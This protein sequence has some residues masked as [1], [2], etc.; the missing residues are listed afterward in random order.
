MPPVGFADKTGTRRVRFVTGVMH[1]GVDYGPDFDEDEADIKPAAALSYVQSGRA[2]YVDVPGEPADGTIVPDEETVI[3]TGSSVRA[4]VGGGAINEGPDDEILEEG[5]PGH[6]ALSK[7]TIT[8]YAQLRA[9]EDVTTIP[10]IGDATAA[11]IRK[12]LAA[13]PAPATTPRPGLDTRN[14]GA[15]V[16]KK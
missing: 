15:A 16:T 6:A 5:F 3:G 9:V 11:E 14:A 1:D 4:V 12:A 8:T 10:G 13:R 7:A 2:V